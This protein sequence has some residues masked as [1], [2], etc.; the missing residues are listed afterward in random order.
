MHAMYTSN[1]TSQN[2]SCD[3]NL[4]VLGYYSDQSDRELPTAVFFTSRDVKQ[5]EELCMNYFGDRVSG[6]RRV[7]QVSTRYRICHRYSFFDFDILPVRI[8][9]DRSNQSVRQI[10]FF[11]HVVH[12]TVAV[13]LYVDLSRDLH[14]IHLPSGLLIPFKFRQ[15]RL[16]YDF[17]RARR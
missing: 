17:P 14:V 6:R 9:T 2:H 10:R 12:P 4:T 1:W 15:C 5:D 7:S 13:P 16:A 8:T 3:P 11:A